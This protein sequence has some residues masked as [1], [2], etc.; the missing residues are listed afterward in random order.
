MVVGLYGLLYAYAAFRLDR[1]FAIILVGLMGK[2]FGP[3]GWVMAVHSGEWPL[4]TFPLV[5]FND[6]IWWVPFALFLFQN[7]RLLQAPEISR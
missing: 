3:I 4:R 1:A 7:R 6:V 5:L 2:I